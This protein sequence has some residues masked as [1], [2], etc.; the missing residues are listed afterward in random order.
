M[1]A[2]ESPSPSNNK[3][4]YGNLFEYRQYTNDFNWGANFND[5]QDKALGVVEARGRI[6]VHDNGVIRSEWMRPIYI[7]VTTEVANKYVVRL[8]QAHQCPIVVTD[9]FAAAL[10][11]WKISSEGESLLKYNQYK[12]ACFGQPAETVYGIPNINRKLYIQPNIPNKSVDETPKI[13]TVAE[14]DRHAKSII[15][16]KSKIKNALEWL[17]P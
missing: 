9:D 2:D 17:F 13:E 12:L 6:L 8:Y 15:T 4:L 11:D 5:I 10:F 3:G 14:L 16:N 1:T 7:I